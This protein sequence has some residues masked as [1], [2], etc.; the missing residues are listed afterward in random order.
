M[1]EDGE[2]VHVHALRVLA[3]GVG[4]GDQAGSGDH[5]G[6]HT[7]TNEQD[8]VL[9]LAL[10]DSIDGPD[11][12][13]LL[14]VVVLE[15]DLVGTG[16]L[17]LDVAPGGGCDMDRGSSALVAILNLPVGGSVLV[18]GEVP[19]LLSIG[20]DLGEL[21]K[22]NGLLASV[23]VV[24][25]MTTTQLLDRQRVVGVGLAVVL[26]VDFDADVKMSSSNEFSTVQWPN[27]RKGRGQ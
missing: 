11:S 2:L 22:V 5:G 14:A 23:L 24:L 1:A 19:G 21:C 9:G 18:V 25:A 6:G 7:V 20:L 10:S 15:H 12:L 3:A 8:D 16:L 4:L 17:D 26:S 27:K 13:S